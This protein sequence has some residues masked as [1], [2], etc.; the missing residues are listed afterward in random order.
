MNALTRDFPN[1]TIVDVGGI[2]RR[3]RRCWTR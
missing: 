2:L 1:L 3:C